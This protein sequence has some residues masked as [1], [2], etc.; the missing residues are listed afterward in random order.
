MI[1]NIKNQVQEAVKEL[2]SVAQLN[3]DD[4]FVL[5][6]SSSEVQGEHIGKGSNQEIGEVVVEEIMQQLNPQGIHLAVQ[7]CEHI[8]RACVVE[9]QVALDKGFEIVDVIPQLDAGGS[10]SIA[11]CKLFDDPVEV[12][13]I[14]AD[15]GLDIGDTFIGMHIKHVAVPVRLKI[16]EVGSAHLT[17]VRRR[18]KK[19]GGERA[20]YN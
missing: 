1:E 19:I 2:L 14:Q 18:P 11:A 9:R 8:N 13:F 17:A 12:E 5:G 7:G 16:K 20:A 15:A 3:E 10:S 4:L 6:M